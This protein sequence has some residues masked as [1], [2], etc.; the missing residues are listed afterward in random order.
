MAEPATKLDKAGAAKE[1]DAELLAALN[2]GLKHYTPEGHD[3]RAD[4]LDGRYKIDVTQPLP[5]FNS[6][7][8]RAY[9]VTETRIKTASFSPSSAR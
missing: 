9:A 3:R 8:A 2:D 5:E 1:T 4:L 7:N 6:K